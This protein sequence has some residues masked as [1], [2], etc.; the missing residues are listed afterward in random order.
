MQ[1]WGTAVRVDAGPAGDRG[2]WH[3]FP[4][5]WGVNVTRKPLE[6]VLIPFLHQGHSEMSCSPRLHVSVIHDGGGFL[7]RQSQDREVTRFNCLSVKF[8]K[9]S[10]YRQQTHLTRKRG[11]GKE[12]YIFFV[13]KGLWVGEHYLWSGVFSKREEMRQWAG[14]GWGTPLPEVLADLT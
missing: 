3:V 2:N 7:L 13:V 6:T 11:R 12:K 10:S 1:S 5:R 14:V 8:L 9:S 4:R